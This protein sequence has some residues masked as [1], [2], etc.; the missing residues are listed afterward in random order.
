MAHNRASRNGKADRRTRT[1][2]SQKARKKIL[3]KSQSRKVSNVQRKK[4]FQRRHKIVT[5]NRLV[6]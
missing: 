2:M 6:A 5:Q 3:L 4:K 1:R